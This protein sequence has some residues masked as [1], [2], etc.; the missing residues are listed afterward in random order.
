M[1]STS[2]K[3]L[4][5]AN[6]YFSFLGSTGQNQGNMTFPLLANLEM[7]N[8]DNCYI[9]TI[10]HETFS[11]IPNLRIL[12][13]QS[14]PLQ[15]FTSAI[16]LKSLNVL[17]LGIQKDVEIDI[18]NE[19][20]N[21]PPETFQEHPMHNLEVLE[22]NNANFGNLSDYHFSG[23][24]NL[25]SLSLARSKFIHFSDRLFGNLTSLTNLSLAYIESQNP[26]ELKKIQGPSKLISLDLTYTALNLSSEQKPFMYR[27]HLLSGHSEMTM[28]P[29]YQSLEVLNLTGTL[30]EF[31]FPLENLFLEY[32]ENL[33]ALELSENKIHAWNKTILT[34]NSNLKHLKLTKN[35]MDII[36][37]DEMIKDLFQSSKLETLDLTENVFICCQ[38]ISS[39]FM[40]ALNRTDLEIVGYKNGTG[41][42]CFDMAN[43]TEV[44]FVD[45]V[46]AGSG[47]EPGTDITEPPKYKTFIVGS[48]IG[49][50]V[51]II[52]VSIAYRKRWYIKYH[53]YWL[54]KKPIKR[55]EPF[56]FDVFISYSQKDDLWVKKRLIPFLEDSEPKLSVCFHER[57][58]DAG[59]SIVEN[60]VDSLDRSR[61]CLLVLSEQ[62]ISS[63]WCMFEAHLASNRLIQASRIG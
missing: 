24:E 36:F 34:K 2:L 39:F 19:Y 38:Q 15:V 25:K 33:T 41:Y 13:L 59:K 60:I 45:F 28:N 27:R 12:S 17:K 54:I 51:I 40:Q 8:L 21:F 14:N 35:G 3:K 23:L 30:L 56:N 53:Y 49:S 7:L 61:K 43:K 16:L 58:F 22:I 52:I 50:L 37:T 26:I 1:I 44:T 6:N 11:N 55:E 57:D 5:L 42:K 18:G 47:I 31:D 63:S 62:Y 4:N 29:M 48:V 20:F 46:T 10:H 9:R 32:I